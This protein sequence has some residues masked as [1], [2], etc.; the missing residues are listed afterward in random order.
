MLSLLSL[1]VSLLLTVIVLGCLAVTF[2]GMPGNWIL[3]GVAAGVHWLAPPEYRAWLPINAIAI[4]G[5][6]A[7]MGEVLEFAAGA[8]GVGKLGG[9]K[10]SAALALLGSLIGAI[11][12]M[13]VGI[14]IPLI[15]SLLASLVLGG[16]GAY[17]GAAIGE[18]WAGRDWSKSLEVG[19]A[20]FWGKL[21]GTF[22]KIA[23]GAI[24][25]GIAIFFFW[26]H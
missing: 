14:P 7:V 2:L 5:A 23:C 9:S 1:F 21:L 10:R 3:L 19:Y 8:L 17:L 16:V 6:L 26:A 13:F 12:G 24:M 15:G 11:G 18:R 22:G 25:A 4:M 20:A